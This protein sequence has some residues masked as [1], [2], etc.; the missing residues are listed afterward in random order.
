[1]VHSTQ[2]FQDS[3]GFRG[4]GSSAPAR[5]QCSAIVRRALHL[6]VGRLWDPTRILG[7]ITGF[8]NRQEL[9]PSRVA[10]NAG[11]GPLRR[12]HH[13]ILASASA[14]G[15]LSFWRGERSTALTLYR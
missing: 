1:M 8:R 2:W 4:K 13:G 7:E 14:E 12:H 3:D 5:F 9:F 10:R 15:A 11:Q 6:P